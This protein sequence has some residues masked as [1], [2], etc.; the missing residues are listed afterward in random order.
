MNYKF[1]PTS[2]MRKKALMFITTILMLQLFLP[3]TGTAAEGGWQEVGGRF[4]VQAGPKHEYFHLYE[5]FAVYELPWD[6]RLSS[7]WGLAPQLETSAGALVGG[8]ETGFIGSLGTGLAFNKP[9][10]GIALEAGGNLNLLDRR[11][12][13]RQDFGSILMWGAYMGVSYRFTSRLGV[14]YRL[15]HLSNNRI[16]YTSNT[17]NPGVDMHMIGVS[18]HF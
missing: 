1:V 12:F 15:Q 16:L 5:A 9:G 14:G 6:W 2:P 4:G 11:Q 7:G 17:P 18:W 10:N 13:G 8:N 3:L